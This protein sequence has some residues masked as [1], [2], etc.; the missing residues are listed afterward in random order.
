MDEQL[1][2]ER[3]CQGA[4]QLWMRGLLA[5]DGGLVSVESHRRRFLVTPPGRRRSDLLPADLMTVDLGGL[6]MNGGPGLASDLWRPHR[7]A[8]QI[9]RET[10]GVGSQA[11][12][13]TVLVTSP[14]LTALVRQQAPG[15]R[16]VAAL[17]GAALPWTDDPADEPAIRLALEN[18]RAVFIRGSGLLAVGH[19]LASALNLVEHLEQAA[20]ITLLGGRKP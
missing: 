13:A 7:I 15:T 5:G 17:C 14:A 18:R 3:V 8:Y 4:Q 19:D 11:I 12:R 16:E 6:D 10:P 1:L 20:Y 2:R 9:E